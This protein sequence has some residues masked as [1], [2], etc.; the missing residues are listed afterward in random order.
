MK[1]INS[2][3][4]FL[5]IIFAGSCKNDVA[6]KDD[7]EIRFRYFN[8]EKNGWKS[9]E[10]IQKVDDIN[11]MASEVPLPYYVL[12]SEGEADLIKVDSI[13]KVNSKERL[14]EF[15]FLQDEQK[16][17]LQTKFT[18]LDYQEGVKYMSFNIEKDFY[19][20]TSK[21]TIACSGVTF[22]RNFKVAPYHKVLLFFTGISPNENIQLIYTDRLF[23]KGIIKFKFQ[24]KISRL[25]L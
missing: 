13:C 2:G 14:I 25:I 4:L 24:D 21:D 9:R 15:Q 11:F 1:A 7:S 17:L 6:V 20:V 18:G 12:K 8:L 16:D 3:I 10:Y 19:V 23:K 5:L 22:E